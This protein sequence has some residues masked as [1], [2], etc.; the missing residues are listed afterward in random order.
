MQGVRS[1]E[2]CGNSRKKK[3]DPQTPE[4]P[5]KNSLHNIDRQGMAASGGA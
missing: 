1:N 3:M 4:Q 2:N 5:R